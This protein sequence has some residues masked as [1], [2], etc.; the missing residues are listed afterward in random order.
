MADKVKCD[1]TCVACIMQGA[2]L[3]LGCIL[4]GAL[5][6][7]YTTILSADATTAASFKLITAAASYFYEGD[8]SSTLR[9][10]C[11]TLHFIRLINHP[12]S[13]F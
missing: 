3:M 12:L 7:D 5:Y 2:F 11:R 13:L 1:F 9:A 10:Y 6:K 4:F 8:T